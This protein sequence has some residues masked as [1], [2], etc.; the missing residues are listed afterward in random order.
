MK[1]DAGTLREVA[2][3]HAAAIDRGF[4]SSLGP[5]FL[6]E[7]YRAIDAAP[8]SF[9]LVEQRDGRVAG[10][11]AG[12]RDLARVRKG[13]LRRPLHLAAAM[14]PVLLRPRKLIGAIEALRAGTSPP[15][16]L[17]PAELLSLA[18][19]HRY[20][21]RGLAESLYRRLERKFASM[22]VPAFRIVVGAD[23]APAHRFY[24]KMGAVARASMEV[25]SGSSSTVYVHVIHQ[26]AAS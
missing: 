5:R 3:L 6:E 7:M 12:S 25:H 8:E 15:P 19:N 26:E 13:L 11:I 10:F 24:R 4:L 14:A 1:A 23:L 22:G 2:L 20:R 21:G 16:G 9:L 18:V 17:P